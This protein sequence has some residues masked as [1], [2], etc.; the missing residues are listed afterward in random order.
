MAGKTPIIP[1]ERIMESIPLIRGEKVILDAD[2]AVFYS[3]VAWALP[4]FN[5][6]GGRCPP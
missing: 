4:T 1:A 2:L 5:R 6:P 3:M